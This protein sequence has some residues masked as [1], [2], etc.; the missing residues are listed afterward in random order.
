VRDDVYWYSKSHNVIQGTGEAWV[1]SRASVTDGYHTRESIEPHLSILVTALADLSSCREF[2][3]CARNLA[4]HVVVGV[5][6]QKP[7]VGGHRHPYGKTEF[8]SGG[9]TIV[10]AYPTPGGA[11]GDS[12]DHAH[13]FA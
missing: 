1:S 9:R 3:V 8:G 4:H 6:D 10:A 5:G 12:S 2:L 7:P 13:R 11:P